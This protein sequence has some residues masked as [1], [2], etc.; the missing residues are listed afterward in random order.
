MEDAAE[1]SVCGGEEGDR[2]AEEP[3]DGPGF[4][5]RREMWAGD[6]RLL[7]LTRCGKASATSGSERR[8]SEVSEWELRERQERE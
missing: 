4:A 6:A 2:E 7:L 3:V 8:P 1:D 5:G